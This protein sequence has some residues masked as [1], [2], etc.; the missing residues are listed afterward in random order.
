M[1][2]KST[3]VKAKENAKKL[4]RLLVS[5]ATSFYDLLE[6]RNRPC[7]VTFCN[8]SHDEKSSQTLVL[9]KQ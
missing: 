7:K 8:G 3:K 4:L 1:F 5:Y 2:A 9:M 6:K